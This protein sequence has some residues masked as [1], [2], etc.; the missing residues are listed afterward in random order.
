MFTNEL[1]V[2]GNSFSWESKLNN[3]NPLKQKKKGHF[4]GLKASLHKNIKL[5]TRI[6]LKFLKAVCFGFVHIL[7][8]E[9]ILFKIMSKN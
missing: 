9:P 8:I 1:N 2:M 5:H 3:P 7:D 4:L 6:F